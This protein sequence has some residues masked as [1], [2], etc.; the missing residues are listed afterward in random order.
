MAKQKS[1]LGSKITKK[2]GSPK[3]GVIHS[4]G[5]WFTVTI[6]FFEESGGGDPY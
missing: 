5:A 6:F 2:N 3:S 4:S 1:L